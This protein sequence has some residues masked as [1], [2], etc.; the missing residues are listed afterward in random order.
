M[1]RRVKSSRKA[2]YGLHGVAANGLT[3][4]VCVFV[5]VCICVHVYV[6]IYVYK[7]VE[8]LWAEVG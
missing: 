1:T 2:T 3:L 4:C 6:C 5:Y 8:E 7:R